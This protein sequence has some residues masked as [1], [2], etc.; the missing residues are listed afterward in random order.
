MKMLVT[1]AGGFLG[2]Y[3]VAVAVRRG[4]EVR[5]MVRPAARNVP[6]D[7]CQHPQVEVVRGDL[8]ARGSFDR[9][10]DG[11]DVV[12]HLAACKTG[13]LY[14]QFNGTVIATENLLDAMARLDVNRLVVTS[15]FSVYDYLGRW[16]WSILDE[17]APLAPKPL[18][19]DEYCRSKLEQ[20]RLVR[21]HAAANSC[22]CII[23]RPGAIYGRDNLWTAR[24]GIQLSDRWWIRTG[25]FAPLPLTYV[26]NCAAAVIMAAEYDKVRGVTTFN[27][28]DD[29]PPSQRAYLNEL[30]R[31]MASSPHVVALPWTL[32]R[33]TARLASWVNQLGFGGTAKV[34]GL[35]VPARLHARCK[36]LR[37]T[38]D[39]ICR[40]LGW[41]PMY[42]WKEGIERALRGD[43]L[44]TLPSDAEIVPSKGLQGQPV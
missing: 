29:Q 12:L 20:E 14:E 44:I 41:K 36:P 16:S 35:L 10:M 38:N 19:R 22:R 17:R 30:C 31:Q 4:H 27:V 23:L 9:M 13:D 5:A 39:K 42:K 3:V 25:T 15:S 28:V 33:C 32:I 6:S 26:E 34:P 37:Y 11:V 24:L 8:R 7:W 18:A 43:D 21:E 2:R 40:T 1:G